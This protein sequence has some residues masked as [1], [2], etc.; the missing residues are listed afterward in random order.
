MSTKTNPT[1]VGAFVVGA[2]AIS[3]IAVMV[4]GGSSFFD[5]RFECIVYF[6][7][8]ISG[9][10]V[11]APVE[12]Q[13]V[14]VGTVTDVRLEVYS[15]AGELLR[16]VRLQLEGGR[17]HHVDAPRHEGDSEAGMNRMVDEH[18][19]RARLASQSLLTGKLKIELGLHP[20]TPVVR[21]NRHTD[22][23]ELPT[24]PSA[25]RQVKQDLSQLP[26]ADMIAESHEAIQRVSLLLDPDVTGR[27]IKKLNTTLDN[28]SSMLSKLDQRIDPLLLSM[29]RTSDQA[30]AFL[31]QDSDLRAELGLLVIEIRKTSQSMRLL[32]DYLEQHPEAILR[33]K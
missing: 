11:G 12:F 8:S 21:L 33:G 1:I 23:F 24:L 28:L 32:T 7:E 27:T 22:V 20:T 25:L 30:G 10:D 18:G 16:P 2:I 29:T 3:V 26:I 13:G 19:L 14:R 5:K 15:K 4:L 9:L 17:F 6:E 31:N